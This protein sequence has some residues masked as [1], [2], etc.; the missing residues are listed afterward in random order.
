[1]RKKLF[2]VAILAVFSASCAV[3]PVTSGFL[4]RSYGKGN[5]AVDGGGIILGTAVPYF[6]AGYGIGA[7]LDLG[8]Q[9][10]FLAIGLFGRYSFI[11]KKEGF[12]LAGLASVGSTAEGSYVYTG[13]ALSYK[14]GFIEPYFVGRFNYVNYDESDTQTGIEFDSG[15]YSYLQFNAGSVFWIS[16]SVGANVEFAFFS[17]STGSADLVGPLVSGG[18]KFRF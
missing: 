6:K 10:D 5:L 4:G 11:N 2:L 17:G 9:Y 16:P 7:N 1:M 18:L 13:P 12:S 8:L 15:S 14:A 3:A